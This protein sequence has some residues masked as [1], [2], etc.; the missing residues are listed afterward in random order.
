LDLGP[1]KQRAL[2]AILLLHANEVVSA[3]RLIDDLW[4]E[5]APRTATKSVQVYV[6][7]LRKQLGERRLVTRKPGYLLRVEPDELDGARFEQIVSEAREAGPERARTDPTPGR[8][9]R[10]SSASRGCGSS[11]LCDAGPDAAESAPTP[12][13]TNRWI[14]KPIRSVLHAS[15]PSP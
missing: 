4:P 13:R 11:A 10:R 5:G 8:G 7:G 2:L 9:A 15:G 3:A 12:A 14:G 1:G 6:S